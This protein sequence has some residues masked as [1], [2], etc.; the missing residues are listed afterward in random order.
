[1]CSLW[2]RKKH[3]K[4]SRN[5]TDTCDRYSNHIAAC[6][7]SNCD[8]IAHSHISSTNRWLVFKISQF[9]G[10][11][12][13]EIAHHELSTVLFSVKSKISC[14]VDIQTCS[15][16]SHGHYYL[17]ESGD[18]EVLKFRSPD[19][20]HLAN[21]LFKEKGRLN[22]MSKLR[23]HRQFVNI[24][25]YC[26]TGEVEHIIITPKICLKTPYE[27]YSTMEISVLNT[28]FSNLPKVH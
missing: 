7:R 16:N 27:E 18:Q 28:H 22:L 6:I 26:E 4:K 24:S 19:L 25:P 10:L 9:V 15:K 23:E 11:S 3:L 8:T 13:F 2:F 20:D 14:T 1:M 17:I 12:C 5:S 21:N